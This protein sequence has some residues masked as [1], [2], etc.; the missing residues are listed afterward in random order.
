MGL[1]PCGVGEMARQ[2]F[3][4]GDA[5]GWGPLAV[6]AG[7]AAALTALLVLAVAVIWTLGRAPST[8]PAVGAGAPPTPTP[9]ALSFAAKTPTAPPAVETPTPAVLAATEPPAPTPAA[10]LAPVEMSSGI[11]A[12]GAGSGILFE[13]ADEAAFSE[14][15]RGSWSAVPNALVS[16]QSAA[17]AEPWLVL[18]EVPAAAFAIEAEIRVTELLDTVCDQSFGLAAGHAGAGQMAGGGVIFPCGEAP[19]RARLSDVSV[20]EDGYNAD[21][22]IAEEEFD[23]GDDWRT[24]RFEVRGGRL[25]LIVDGTAVLT[26]T[27]ETP[28]DIAAGENEAGLWAQGVGIEVR[29]I[30]VYPL[31]PV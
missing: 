13:A 8:V 21:P 20:W 31:P 17:L 29:R 23:P 24:Y 1:R 5:R 3:W 10:T 27:P 15:A 9:R 16:D 14:L 22:V 4:D 26:A 7:V 12:Q 2:T 11:E 6:A 28:L 18:A 25:R 19:S 30:A